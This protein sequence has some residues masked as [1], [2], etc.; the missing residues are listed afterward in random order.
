[1][2]LHCQ[3]VMIGNLELVPH[4]AVCGVILQARH[5]AQLLAYK[6]LNITIFTKLSEVRQKRSGSSNEWPMHS[7][8][9]AAQ[10]LAFV[11]VS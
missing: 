9:V 10:E 4:A 2:A 7:P 3:L 6:V 1:M 5:R 8:A 11:L